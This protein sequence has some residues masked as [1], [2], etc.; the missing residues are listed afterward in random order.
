YMIQADDLT[1]GCKCPNCAQRCTACLG[2]N[3]VFSKEQIKDLKNDPRF[4]EIFLSDL[5]ELKKR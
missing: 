4:C 3:T 1:L 2:T 5:E